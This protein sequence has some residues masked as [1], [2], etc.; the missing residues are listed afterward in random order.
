MANRIALFL[1]GVCVAVCVAAQQPPP[2][3][4]PAVGNAVLL[5]TNSIQVDRD[6]VVTRGDLVVN[7]AGGQLTI[8]QNFRFPAGFALKA[9]SVSIARG[10]TVDGDIFYNMLHDDGL[11][12]GHLV[13]PLALPVIST[14]PSITDHASGTQSVSLGS[15]EVRVVGT[16][17]F[18]ALTLGKNSTLRLPGGPYTFASINGG[19][20]ATIIFDGPADVL[21]NGNITFGQSTTIAAGPGVTTK[22]KMIFSKGAITIGKDSTIAATLF[23]PNGLID[24]GQTLSLTG[25]FVAHDIHVARSST[26]ALRS[27]FR[28]LP[29]VANSQVVQVPGTNPVVITLTG[30]DPDLDPLHFSIGVAPSNGTLGAVV[31]AGPTSAVVVYTPRVA[32]PADVFTFRVTDSEGF[33]ADGVVTINEGKE[34]PGPPT[35]IIAS[36]DVVTVPA[37]P[38]SILSLNAIAPQGVQ[39]TISIVAGSGPS[40]GSLGPVTQGTLNPPHPASVVYAPNPGYVGDDSFQFQACGV[41]SD[42][43]VCSVGTIHIAVKGFEGGELAPDLTVDS[44]SG[45]PTPITLAPSGAAP[46]Q[47]RVTSLPQ[48]GTLIDS[49]G[50]PITSVPYTLPSPIVTYQSPSGFTG[51]TSFTYSASN[52]QGSDSGTVTINVNPAPGSEN[53]GAIAPDL[54]ASTTSGTPVTILITG[55]AAT[56]NQYRVLALPQDGTLTDGNGAVITSVAYALPSP[57]VTYQSSAAFIGTITIAYD[58][59]D[60]RASDTGTITVTVNAPDNGRG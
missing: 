27:G 7:D 53:N 23:A 45:E 6:T 31:P 51:Q 42:Q 19:Q 36:D 13:T 44:T 54:S 28:N 57:I 14:L 29:P 4:P 39:V 15:G 2:P 37:G 58:G 10:S 12:T 49:S 41:I 5:A 9:N 3:L 1:T 55:G 60:G 11:S 35:T 32:D 47:Y 43:Q 56:T 22:H 40:F 24:A 52:N 20:G 30:S 33:F 46:A 25:S 16:G 8:D 26:L 59:S 38:P 17:D 21:V 48:T 18:G 50:A 34:L